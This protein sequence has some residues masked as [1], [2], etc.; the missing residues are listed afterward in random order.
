M[1]NFTTPT[2]EFDV[3]LVEMVSLETNDLQVEELEDRIEMA[4]GINWCWCCWFN[5][6]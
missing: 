2:S 6:A 1:E 4:A 3:E 5:E